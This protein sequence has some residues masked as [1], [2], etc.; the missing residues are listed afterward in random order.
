MEVPKDFGCK[1]SLISDD[2][3]RAVL[4]Y[5]NKLR[6]KV[7]KGEQPTN[8]GKATMP[9]AAK[10]N[11]L[12]WDCGLEHNAWLKL[13]NSSTD[14]Y[15]F[16]TT[17][18]KTPIKNKGTPCNMTAN[19]LEVLKTFAKESN[20]VD[21]SGQNPKRDD[22]I[23]NFAIMIAEA[24]KGF[25]CSY[26]RC[27]GSTETNFLCLYDTLMV[28]DNQTYESI[29]DKTKACDSCPAN[30]NNPN[31]IEYLCQYEYTLAEDAFPS[32][33][34]YD[35]EMTRDMQDTAIYMHNYYRKLIATGWAKSKNGYAPRAKNMNA[36]EYDCQQSGQEA[37]IA[38]NCTTRQYNTVQGYS[39]N[40]K[41]F[42][43]QVT[44]ADALREAISAWYGELQSVDIDEKAT[45]TDQIQTNAKNFANMA[46]AEASK[47]ACSAQQCNA[48]GI[49]VALCVY[50][51]I[52]DP[53]SPLYDVGKPC[54]GCDKT[55]TT[56]DQL[57]G[58]CVTN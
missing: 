54:A 37:V 44:P 47:F 29:A 38:L 41:E 10:M 25:A 55:K 32:V 17:T 53:D 12:T 15:P 5:H 45:Y 58:L 33:Y 49:T 50:K 3:R 22:K 31:C 30:G 43:Y 23:A 1:N 46:L 2:W 28:A 8:G 26:Q 6:R 52:P 7:A 11:E 36:L 35:D 42:S 39:L 20:A 24:A 18:I 48:Q 34:C 27:S 4:D 14:V 51:S 19:T 57:N 40:Y 56:C 16:Y 13:C 9:A 21:L